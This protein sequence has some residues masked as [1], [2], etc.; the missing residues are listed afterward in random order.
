M[1]D[2]ILVLNVFLSVSSLNPA[3]NHS[4]HKSWYLRQSLLVQSYN[5][6][7]H[8]SNHSILL[9]PKIK[10]LENLLFQVL[11]IVRKAEEENLTSWTYFQWF[12]LVIFLADMI[13]C[14]LAVLQRRRVRVWFTP[15]HTRDIKKGSNCC[16]VWHVTL[17]VRVG[18][19]PGAG[20]TY[21][22]A[23]LELPDKVPSIKG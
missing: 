20:A 15:L 8:F 2:I 18:E 16:Y 3:Q 13:E 23:Q 4:F 12:K 21:Y 9:V 5:L 7:R 6:I 10:F 22:H 17:I 14:L 11:M 19:M 1:D